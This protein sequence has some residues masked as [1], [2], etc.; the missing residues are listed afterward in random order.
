V[1]VI[2][3]FADVERAEGITTSNLYQARRYQKIQTRFKFFITNFMKQY[4]LLGGPL[5]DELKKQYE[6]SP[7]NEKTLME[8]ISSL[9]M[10]LPEADTAALKAQ[11]GMYGEYSEFLR[12]AMDAFV[13]DEMVSSML[14]GENIGSNIGAIRTSIVNLL[15]RQKLTSENMLPE[16]TSLFMVDDKNI[17]D[18]IADYNKTLISNI[19]D[20]ARKTIKAETADD[21][22]TTKLNES[23]GLTTPDE[24]AEDESTD[25]GS[26]AEGGDDETDNFGFDDSDDGGD[27]SLGEGD[28]TPDESIPEEGTDATVEPTDEPETDGGQSEPTDDADEKEKTEPEDSKKVKEEDNEEEEEPEDDSEDDNDEAADDDKK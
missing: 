28:D 2:D 16:L 4:I 8:L 14:H 6:E 18:L 19:G 20:L 24:P 15:L 9:E 3:G 10:H 1:E 11:G 7:S 23:L 27:D 26:D 5:F 25:D 12:V 21:A 13:S 17:I 22:K